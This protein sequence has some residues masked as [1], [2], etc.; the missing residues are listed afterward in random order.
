MGGVV[1]CFWRSRLILIGS[2]G[3]KTNIDWGGGGREARLILIGEGREK[4][5]RLI[6]IGK[7][8]RAKG[9]RLILIRE[10]ERAKGARLILIREGE[11]ER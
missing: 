2:E 10:G 7:G 1:S 11:R 3:V 5:A 6:L 9:A 4:G 8:E